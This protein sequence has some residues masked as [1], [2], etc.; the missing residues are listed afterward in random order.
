MRRNW[1]HS[2]MRLSAHRK[3]RLRPA[4]PT[5]LPQM[6]SEISSA[7]A[8]RSRKSRKTG[9]FGVRKQ[10]TA[11]KQNPAWSWKR[12]GKITGAH[13]GQ[14]RRAERDDRAD[15]LTPSIP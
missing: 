12:D 3:S 11:S 14:S 1:L 2:L 7:C 9:L 10:R 13:Q 4:I 5:N 6:T 8:I 15:K